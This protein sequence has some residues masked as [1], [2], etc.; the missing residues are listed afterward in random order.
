MFLVLT[1][2]QSIQA[3]NTSESCHHVLHLY[4]HSCGLKKLTLVSLDELTGLS[5]CHQL[6]LLGEGGIHPVCFRE[7]TFSHDLFL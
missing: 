1:Q 6:W 7:D 4:R 2:I 5:G 3:Q